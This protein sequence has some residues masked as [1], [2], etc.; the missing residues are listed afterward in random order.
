MATL[1]KQIT[2]IA[3]P[4]VS[5]VPGSKTNG[6]TATAVDGQG[7]DRVCHVVQL[8]SFGTSAG[9]DAEIT[10]SATSGGSYTLIAS[11]GMAL[12]TGSAANTVILI[13][14]PVNSSK[15]F[16]KIR[17]TATTAAVGM[18]AVALCY[19]GTGTK[20]TTAEDVNQSVYVP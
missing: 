15:P 6:I 8:G 9:F 19:L 3:E 20:P 7:F 5:V 13:D 14:V 4:Q 12:V 17:S 18:S 2:A 11:S 16:Q 10:E 1:K